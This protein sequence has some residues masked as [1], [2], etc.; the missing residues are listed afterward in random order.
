[1][2][3]DALIQLIV[4]ACIVFAFLVLR[5]KQAADFGENSGGAII[6]ILSPLNQFKK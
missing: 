3:K 4:L 2:K 5:W 1:M 6:Q